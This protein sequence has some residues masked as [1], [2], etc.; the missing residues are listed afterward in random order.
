M[1]LVGSVLSLIIAQESG[2]R[3][4]RS[5]SFASPF[6]TIAARIA[7]AQ[8]Q[9]AQLL[10]ALGQAV[11]LQIEQQLQAVLGLAQEAIGVVEDA[12]FLIG[13]AADALEGGQGQQ[14]VALA[15]LRADRRR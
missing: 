4:G 1:R 5:G 14:G 10:L 9:L 8:G 12:I 15:D 2:Q 11:R 7:H 6:V 3:I 13:Q